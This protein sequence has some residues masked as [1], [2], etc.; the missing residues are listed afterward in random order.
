MLT[1]IHAP[2]PTPNFMTAEMR[3]AEL[4]CSASSSASIVTKY[5]VASAKALFPPHNIPDNRLMVQGT[6]TLT[7]S[8]VP[9]GKVLAQ[10]LCVGALYSTADTRAACTVIAGATCD[11][12][13]L[14]PKCSTVSADVKRWRLHAVVCVCFPFFRGS[15]ITDQRFIKTRSFVNEE[16]VLKASHETQGAPKGKTPAFNLACSNIPPVPLLEGHRLPQSYVR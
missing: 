3:E 13:A 5:I 12:M 10:P 14:A 2:T 16:A 8:T 15:G 11:I 4:P 9:V 1:K 7:C 6:E